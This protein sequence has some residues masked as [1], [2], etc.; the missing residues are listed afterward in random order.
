V[1]VTSSI[2]IILYYKD[3]SAGGDAK[4]VT[5]DSGSEIELPPM[6]SALHTSLSLE[7]LYELEEGFEDSD[8]ENP[9]AGAKQNTQHTR[10][11]QHHTAQ[12][13][14]AES[15]GKGTGSGKFDF[16]ALKASLASETDSD[17]MKSD[18]EYQYP[19]VCVATAA[20]GGSVMSCGC[21]AVWLCLL[22][23]RILLPTALFVAVPCPSYVILL[24]LLWVGIVGDPVHYSAHGGPDLDLSLHG[25][26]GGLL[27]ASMRLHGDKSGGHT[28]FLAKLPVPLFG[29]SDG[30]L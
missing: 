10:Y 28:G 6:H 24:V 23:T 19:L 27:D 15:T 1:L 17:W 12:R 20:D 22:R 14:A 13:S 5:T 9:L 18:G 30:G 3:N 25:E 11:T 7:E 2:F 26:H 29:A 8:T 21:F 4:S 16:A